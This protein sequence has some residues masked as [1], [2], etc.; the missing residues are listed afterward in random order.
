MLIKRVWLVRMFL[1]YIEIIRKCTRVNGTT[2]FRHGSQ[3]NPMQLISSRQPDSLSASQSIRKAFIEPA[4]F[5][6]HSTKNSL[7]LVLS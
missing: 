5:L 1:S 2:F 4:G 6:F 3:R 7:P